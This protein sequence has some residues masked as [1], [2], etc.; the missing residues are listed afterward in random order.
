MDNDKL[1][2]KRFKVRRGG[3]II[4]TLKSKVNCLPTAVTVR[5]IHAR[6]PVGSITGFSSKQSLHFSGTWRFNCRKA[7]QAQQETRNALCAFPSQLEIW[8]TWFR[9]FSVAS[10]KWQWMCSELL[11]YYS[12]LTKSSATAEKARVRVIMLFKTMH[13]VIDF[14]GYWIEALIPLPITE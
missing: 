3:C 14:V 4:A 5:Q 13:S 6:R 11:M 1:R 10:R 8:V 9:A 12:V 2:L 7:T